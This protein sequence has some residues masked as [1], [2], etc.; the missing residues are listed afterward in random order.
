MAASPSRARRDGPGQDRNATRY[1][2]RIPT[3]VGEAA[4]TTSA[5]SLRSSNGLR[6][7]KR[8]TEVFE[9][10]RFTPYIRLSIYR[11]TVQGMLRALFPTTDPTA[12][13]VDA[14]REDEPGVSRGAA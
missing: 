12:A 3:I 13:D 1:S 7:F 10:Y 4:W 2:L 8:L 5:A 11:G 9:R 6:A 14:G